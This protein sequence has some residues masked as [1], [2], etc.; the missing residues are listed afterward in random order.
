[1]KTLLNASIV[2]LTLLLFGCTSGADNSGGQPIEDTGGNSNNDGGSTS[3]SPGNDTGGSSTGDSGTGGSN[4]GGDSGSTGGDTGGGGSSGG[5][6][7]G[8]GSLSSLYSTQ[9]ERVN[10]HNCNMVLMEPNAAVSFAEVVYRLISQS[11]N[12]VNS[13]VT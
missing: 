4:S 9:N 13:N 1:M 12:D 8:F 5:T 7:P 6:N 2:V 10:V 3:N 11:G